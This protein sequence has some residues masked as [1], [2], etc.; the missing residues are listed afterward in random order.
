MNVHD[1]RGGDAMNEMTA[2]EQAVINST[3]FDTPVHG[4]CPKW[5]TANHNELVL[6]GTDGAEHSGLSFDDSLDDLHNWANGELDR[7][8]GGSYTMTVVQWSKRS[9]D[10]HIAYGYTSDPLV[11]ASF[12]SNG[13]RAELLM[14]SGEVR[15]LARRLERIADEIDLRT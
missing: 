4:Q 13:Q 6:N 15:T 8:G 14:T 5:C 10:G 2:E 11:E 7:K 9:A 1:V 3:R 12:S